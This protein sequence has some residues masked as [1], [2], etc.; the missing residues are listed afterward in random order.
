MM[1]LQIADNSLFAHQNFL[2]SAQVA[3]IPIPNQYLPLR[4]LKS[5]RIDCW[6]PTIDICGIVRAF[7]KISKA[8]LAAKRSKATRR[9]R[10]MR[11]IHVYGLLTLPAF[12][13][14]TIPLRCR[15]ML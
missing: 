11:R 13:L 5:C 9:H 15:R 4:P 10:P 2:L 12:D 6:I 8:P 3:L 7:D 1:N 14:D